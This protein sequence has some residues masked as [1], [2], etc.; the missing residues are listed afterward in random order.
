VSSLERFAAKCCTRQ[1]LT[2]EEWGLLEDCTRLTHGAKNLFHL[3][4]RTA[5]KRFGKTGKNAVYRVVKKLEAEG[6]LLKVGGRVRN[7]KT[8]K[9]DHTVFEILDHDK[10]CKRYGTKS[11]GP[12]PESGQA[13]VPISSSTSPDFVFSPVPESGHNSVRSLCIK[14]SVKTSGIPSTPK[15]SFL[16]EQ[17]KLGEANGVCSA[18]PDSRTGMQSLHP[19][20]E[21]D[22]RE[23]WGARRDIGRGLTN[24]EIAEIQR[25]NREHVKPPSIQ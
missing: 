15:S 21:Y 19:F 20:A 10:W 11:C 7:Q 6:W 9:F 5:A 3:D 16:Q 25:L 22:A 8:G 23:G 17:E 18:S 4:G 12:V 13:P 14:T 1:H 24:G 2:M